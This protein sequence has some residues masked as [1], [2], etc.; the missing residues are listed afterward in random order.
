LVVLQGDI[1]LRKQI[2]KIRV[3]ED[4][5]ELEARLRPTEEARQQAATM[6]TDSAHQLES[7]T[8]PSLSALD[9]WCEVDAERTT[10][11]SKRLTSWLL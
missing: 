9:D 7:A 6:R 1:S 3:L 10:S 8:L 5:T 4:A 2:L 11:T